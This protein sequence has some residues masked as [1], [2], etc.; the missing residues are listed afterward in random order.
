M[1]RDK[2][3][4]FNRFYLPQFLHPAHSIWYGVS[5]DPRFMPFDHFAFFK[6]LSAV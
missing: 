2:A 1:E 6:L 5:V 3:N 4:E